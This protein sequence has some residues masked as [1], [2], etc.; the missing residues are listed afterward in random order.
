MLCWSLPW[1]IG[2]GVLYIRSSGL[3]KIRNC[4]LPLC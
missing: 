2:P 4:I 3:G 1:K